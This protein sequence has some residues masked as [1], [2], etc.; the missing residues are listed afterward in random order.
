MGEPAAGYSQLPTVMLLPGDCGWIRRPSR[1]ESGGK[2]DC[3]RTHQHLKSMG[4]KQRISHA[5]C[6]AGWQT[7]ENT[8]RDGPKT[9]SKLRRTAAPTDTG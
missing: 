7:A 3:K 6:G 2:S 1:C 5:A 9:M 4:T 8:M